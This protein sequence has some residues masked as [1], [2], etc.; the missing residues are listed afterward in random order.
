MYLTPIHPLQFNSYTNLLVSQMS[1]LS[2][3][4]LADTYTESIFQAISTIYSI[5][6]QHGVMVYKQ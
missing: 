1:L 5:Y 6:I 3:P 2:V 4:S